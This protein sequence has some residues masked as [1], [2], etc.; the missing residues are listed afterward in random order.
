MD[1]TNLEERLRSLKPRRPSPRVER[2]IF[3]SVAAPFWPRRAELWS[4]LTPVAVCALTFLVQAARQQVVRGGA[5]GGGFFATF[6]VNT[7]SSSNVASY[8]LSGGD[9]NL[10]WNVWPHAGQDLRLAAREVRFAV[11]TNR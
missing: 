1:T 4:W 5:E 2:R 8:T 6:I 9:E 7:A 10:E 3:G 11:P